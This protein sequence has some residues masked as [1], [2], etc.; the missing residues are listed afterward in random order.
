MTAFA[1]RPPGLLGLAQEYRRRSEWNARFEHWERPESGSE[2]DRMTRARDMVRDALQI[3]SALTLEGVR[4]VEQG[5]YTNRTNT[6]N[7]ADIDLRVEHPGLRVDTDAT[8]GDYW[9]ASSALGYEVPT[10]ARRLP[11]I[12]RDMRYTIERLLVASFGRHSVDVTGN[13]AI[14]VRGVDGSRG[15]VDVVPGFTLH[16]ISYSSL[17]TGYT[18]TVGFAIHGRDGTWTNSFPDQHIANGRD[19][20]SRTGHQF[21]RV[22]RISKRLRADMA[23]ARV[24][25]GKAP[26]FLVEC[27]IYLADDW[28][29]T[30][31]TDDRYDRV[32]RV[33]ANALEKVCTV[34][35]LNEVNEIKPLFGAGQAWARKDAIAFLEAA[36]AHLGNA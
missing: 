21:K 15:D 5:S 8:V 12:D 33:L 32:R 11:D 36:L 31:A 6:R 22:V 23:A 2:A 24:Y 14:R 7:D 27:L 35:S 16:Q 1:P 3:S 19:K 28:C 17:L 26:S 29:F 4:L 13:K 34:Q 18:T 10:G 25:T 30:V 9:S 20:R